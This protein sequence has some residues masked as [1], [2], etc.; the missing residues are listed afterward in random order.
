MATEL[1]KKTIRNLYPEAL[2]VE[3]VIA[4]LTPLPKD[5]IVLT[6]GCDCIGPAAEI[7]YDGSDHSVM[8]AR[9]SENT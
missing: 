2:T 9:S 8:I 6:E 7:E 5:A 4:K 1:T 3:Q